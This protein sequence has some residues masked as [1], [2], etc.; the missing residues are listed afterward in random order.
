M[1]RTEECDQLLIDSPD[2]ISEPLRIQIGITFYATDKSGKTKMKEIPSVDES[3]RL[4][5]ETST[6]ELRRGIRDY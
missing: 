4:K 2:P 5:R 6:S 3:E 1:H